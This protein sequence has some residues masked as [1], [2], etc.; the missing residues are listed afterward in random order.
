MDYVDVVDPIVVDPIEVAPVT[1]TEEEEE[2]APANFHPY[3]QDL[4][5]RLGMLP[6]VSQAKGSYLYLEDGRE[7]LDGIAQYGAVPFGHNNPLINQAIMEYLSMNQPGFIQPFMPETSKE[8]SRR[9]CELTSRHSP[10]DPYEFV[11]YSNSG[12]ETVEAA[13]K[14]AR[15]KTKRT[16]VLSAINSFH[17]KTYSALSATGS[18]RYSNDHTVCSTNFHKVP[19]NDIAALEDA[20]SSKDYAAFLV[21]P[22][23]GEGG[24][25]PA[26]PKY[27]QAAQEICHKTK[28]LLVL[29]EIQ[30]G[31]GRTGSLFAKDIYNVHPD[32]ILLSK[33]L[34]GGAYR[35][36][37]YIER[38]DSGMCAAVFCWRKSPCST[39][40]KRS[41][42]FESNSTCLLSSCISH[43]CHGDKASYIL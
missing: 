42:R 18:T 8:L 15:T 32:I 19:M 35:K 28:T 2:D 6:K 41:T 10:D 21:E 31:L 12:A 36:S 23:Q 26:T 38:W 33:A 14:L 1:E 13:I 16:K 25:I 43:W 29:D 40:K 37:Q 9:L 34:G 4:L 24:M 20:L 30:T 5:S 3:R 39:N 7:I 27:L 17:G 22:V 11:V